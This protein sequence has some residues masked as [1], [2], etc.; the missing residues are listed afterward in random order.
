MA[1]ERRPKGT[2][3]IRARGSGYEATYSYID[4][5]GR[6]RRRSSTFET[7]TEAREWLT[8]RIARTN[9]DTPGHSENVTV[10]DYLSRWADAQLAQV[11]EKTA[12]WYRWAA[13][14]HLIPALGHLRLE[15]LSAVHIDHLLNSKRQEGTGRE[16][17]RAIRVTLGKAMA[18]AVRKGLVEKNPVVLA[19]KPRLP[20]P[21][22][23][24]QVWTPGEIASFLEAIET[25]RMSALW[26]T[27]AM[28]GM[29]RSEVCGLQWSDIDLDSGSVAVRRA[30]VVVR[31]RPRVKEPKTAR[32]RRTV[33][34]DEDTVLRI[35]DWRK[36]QLEERLRA[37]ASWSGGDWVFTDQLGRPVNPEWVGKQF[38]RLIRDLDLSPIT[39]RQL[40]HSHA[41]AL[42][43]A[44]VHPKVVQERLGHSS[45]AVTLDT[46]SS[47][48]P[49][50]QREAV[51]RLA[52]LI[53]RS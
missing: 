29:R 13:N 37:G 35:R 47:V 41:T 2:G 21:D 4:G 30:V 28:T 52:T 22:A 46:Y 3:S 16:T 42:L 38:R 7:K 34:L 19:D 12:S 43:R 10:G 50:M 39:M 20:K 25:D 26:R 48:L 45:I 23:T 51:E 27:A 18:D 15:K 1:K 6:R 14:K 5:T 49:T 33:D 36:R 32:S 40:R 9:V 8:G 17:L 44:G 31:G 24:L 11:S 53:E